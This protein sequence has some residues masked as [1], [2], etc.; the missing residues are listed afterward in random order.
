VAVALV[1]AVLAPGATAAPG[2]VHASLSRDIAP[3]I[4]PSVPEWFTVVGSTLFFTAD[5]P[6]Y[7]RE[8]WKT[9]AAGTTSLVRNIV[10]GATGSTPLDLTAVGSTLFF[11]AED[12]AG[13]REL[14]K[15]D[16]TGAGTTRVRNIRTVA[17]PNGSSQPADLT[18]A[19]GI[20]YFAATDNAGDRE[21][22]KSNGIGSG[23][24]RVRDIFVG[25]SSNPAHLAAYAGE[26]F[27][28]ATQQ[29]GTRLW[30]TDGTPTGTAR[31]SNTG[32]IPNDLLVV[33]SKL[34]FTGN[35]STYNREP[36]V[37]DGTAAGTKMLRNLDPDPG[38][39]SN[40]TELTAVGDTL[41][42]SA[43]VGGDR[44]LY[45]SDGTTAGTRLVRNVNLAQDTDPRELTEYN[46]ILYFSGSNNFDEELYKSD[47]TYGGTV[48]VK[49]IYNGGASSP[50][51]LTVVGGYLFFHARTFFDTSP[52]AMPY[53]QLVRSDGTAA[54]TIPFGPAEPDGD[55]L[56]SALV[57]FQGTL[58]YRES[59][60]AT[61]VELWKATIEN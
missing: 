4:Y 3:G 57:D 53:D 51:E 60:P 23:T 59:T 9:T 30:R 36:W 17:P 11:T 16:G 38:I 37:S 56:P 34:F 28:R 47:G 43:D 42:F 44:E 1:L 25:G 55:N 12:S 46:G 32:M 49:D 31:V 29:N 26:L 2:D 18:E 33:G 6:T 7:G 35:V 41:F 27:F 13:D 58:Y 52:P 54:G 15:S 21:L 40:P 19:N 39:P 20:L 5:H 22:W 10:P 48:L 8:L 45:K 61:G 14:W 50:T 24:V